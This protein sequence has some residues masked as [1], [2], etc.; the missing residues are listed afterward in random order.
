MTERPNVAAGDRTGAG[1]ARRTRAGAL[2]VA[3]VLATATTAACTQPPVP[4][5]A[6]TPGWTTTTL[7]KGLPT[8]ENVLPEP[9]GSLLLSVPGAN[10]LQRRSTDGRIT[11][12]AT[13]LPG[14]GGLAREGRWVHITTG[15]TS[16]AM[17]TG[18]TDGTIVKV[19]PATGERQ[20][21]ARRLVAPN[22]L[23]I[24]A[25]GS[26]VTTVPLT[27]GGPRTALTRVSPTAPD[28]PQRQWSDLTGTNGVALDPSGQWLYV[29]RSLAPKAEVWRVSVSDPARKERVAQ[30][31]EALTEFLDD[32]TVAADGT[33][34]VAADLSGKIHR[35]D[36]ATGAHCEVATGLTGVAAVKWVAG[37]GPAGH[38]VA[39]SR[40]GVIYQLTP[41]A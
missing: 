22:G 5:A 15:N 7:A 18:S 12:V 16:T 9:D 26:A 19:D 31:G 21:W 2:A 3:A 11:T 13:G 1:G 41:R 33:V 38:L 37:P 14:A 4:G 35:V 27:L 34:F 20:S 17:L 23:A 8:L 25:D 29:S 40:N 6:C 32:L 24:L 28:R 10:A 30:V 39:V 36:P